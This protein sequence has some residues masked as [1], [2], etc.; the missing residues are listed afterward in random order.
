MSGATTSVSVISAMSLSCR[1]GAYG[2]DDVRLGAL[3][4]SEVTGEIFGWHQHDRR[5]SPNF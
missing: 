4:A 2:D 5:L 1:E 3:P